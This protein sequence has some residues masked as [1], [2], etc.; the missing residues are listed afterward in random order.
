MNGKHKQIRKVSHDTPGVCKTSSPPSN[1]HSLF[2]PAAVQSRVNTVLKFIPHIFC[3]LRRFSGL[4]LP[5]C[6]LP[7]GLPVFPAVAV[8]VLVGDCS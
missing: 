7:V 5:S 6:V 4:A 8:T 1:Q 2:F 3:C